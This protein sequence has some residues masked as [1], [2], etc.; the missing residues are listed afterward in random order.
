MI[1]L[2]NFEGGYEVIVYKDLKDLSNSVEWQD[3][4]EE[5]NI[6]L[7]EEGNTYKWDSDKKNEFGIVYD[8]TLIK[9]GANIQLVKKCLRVYQNLGE[10]VEFNISDDSNFSY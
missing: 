10:P 6:I 1:F 3:I 9:S 7:D 2:I 4:F 5:R 8:Y